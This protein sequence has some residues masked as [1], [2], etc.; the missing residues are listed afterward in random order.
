MSLLVSFFLPIYMNSRIFS[1][2]SVLI[3]YDFN[4]L[5]VKFVQAVI[6]MLIRVVSFWCLRKMRKLPEFLILCFKLINKFVLE[7]LLAL[8][9]RMPR[10]IPVDNHI[11]NFQFI[12]FYFWCQ[13]FNLFL[14][15]TMFFKACYHILHFLFTLT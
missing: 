13:L 11:E 12:L 3:W 5:L 10:V 8:I 14:A 4:Q 6:Q 2:S 15:I 1:W 9:V 7:Y